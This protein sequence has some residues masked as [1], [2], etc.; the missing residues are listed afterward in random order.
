L[1]TSDQ[2]LREKLLAGEVLGHPYVIGEIACGTL[3]RRATVL[4][5]LK[6]L[7]QLPVVA[8][9]AVLEL[10]EREKLYGLGLS[11]VDVQL[12][13]VCLRAGCRLYTADQKLARAAEMLGVICV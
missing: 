1:R 8:A 7:P 5:D 3:S 2:R 13:A 10:I 4:G 9:E 11:F 12:L 6:L